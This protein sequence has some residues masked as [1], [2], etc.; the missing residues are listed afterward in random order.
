MQ[1]QQPANNDHS[2]SND[3]ACWGGYFWHARMDREMG[4]ALAVVTFPTVGMDPHKA[5]DQDKPSA[6]LPCAWVRC[7]CSCC[8]PADTRA[9]ATQSLMLPTVLAHVAACGSHGTCRPSQQRI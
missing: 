5:P 3:L 9:C 6:M 2:L 8:R 7:S 4:D 1:L